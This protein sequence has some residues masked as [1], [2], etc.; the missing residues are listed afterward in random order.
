M[1]GPGTSW[2]YSSSI[3]VGIGGISVSGGTGTRT[4]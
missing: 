4:I 1:T 2:W 3:C